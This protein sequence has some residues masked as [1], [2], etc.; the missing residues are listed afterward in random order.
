[1]NEQIDRNPSLLGDQPSATIFAHMADH[2]RIYEIVQKSRDNNE[3]NLL[4]VG[5]QRDV[6]MAPAFSESGC[7]H[8][9]QLWRY[10]NRLLNNPVSSAS[11]TDLTWP[12]LPAAMQAFVE[13]AVEGFRQQNADSLAASRHC[14]VVAGTVEDHQLLHHPLCEIC[15]A[16]G[17]LTAPL[18]TAES[19][20]KP[21]QSAHARSLNHR[22]LRKVVQDKVLDVDHGIVRSLARPTSGRVIPVAAANGHSFG[23]PG[24]VTWSFGRTGDFG[25]DWLVACLEAVERLGGIVPC[26]GQQRVRASFEELGDQAIDP[27]LFILP[28]LSETDGQGSKFASFSA[29]APH[30]WCVGYSIGRARSVLIPLQLAYYGAAPSGI[31][32]DIFVD[33]NSNG[34]ALGGSLLEAA[35]HGLLELLERDAFLRHYYTEAVVSV[36][37]PEAFSDPVIDGISARIRSEGYTV[38]FLNLPTGTA[39]HAVAARLRH[40]ESVTG[41]NLAFAAGAHLSPRRAARAAVSEVASNIQDISRQDMLDKQKRGLELLNTPDDVRSM[42]DHGLQGWTKESLELRDFRTRS[43][44]PPIEPANQ[45]SLSEAFGSITDSLAE[46]GIDVIIVNQSHPSLADDGLHCVKVLAPGLLPMTFGH[47][48]RRAS[49]EALMRL[50]LE[51]AKVSDPEHIRPHL[52]Q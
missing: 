37:P 48:R 8:C 17:A 1:M 21:V 41:P 42:E 36:S 18:P 22:Q 11:T 2:G 39:A 52:F 4:V 6:W 12:D 25:T 14:D 20:Q 29:S 26:R 7:F 15:A 43:S 44:D 46:Q 19:F 34:C 40:D 45:I 50:P 35:F 23:G 16:A 9:F 3:R 30:D 24:S 49:T 27:R 28:E 13:A 32:N 10:D 47:R 5:D 51:D 33:E 31:T 38:D